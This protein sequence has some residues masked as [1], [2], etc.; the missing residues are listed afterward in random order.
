M[1][2]IS[3]KGFEFYWDVASGG[4]EIVDGAKYRCLDPD[5][6]GPIAEYYPERIFFFGESLRVE[7]KPP[8]LI[9]N[10]A[11]EF[12]PPKIYK[13]LADPVL[14]RKFASLKTENLE[15]EVLGFASKYGM[16]GPTL[17]LHPQN[18]SAIYLM[19]P[20]R[21]TD[22][23]QRVPIFP[24]RGE[25]LRI[26]QREID[27]MGVLLA[28]W[29]LIRHEK[30]G[31]L[32]QIITWRG[33]DAVVVRFKWKPANGRYEISPADDE[34][35]DGHHAGDLLANDGNPTAFFARYRR[36]DILGPA[37]HYVCDM[38]NHHL[39]GITPRLSVNSGYKVEYTPKS[40]LDALWLMFMLEVDGTTTTCWH[41]GKSFEPTRKDNVYCSNNCKRM[42]FYHKNTVKGGT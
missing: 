30:V 20:D 33:P 38:L 16:L 32:G 29:D 17:R 27:K 36:G 11:Q 41:C 8:W 24:E 26:W 7:T 25:S 6:P 39:A 3:T 35:S 21:F 1:A 5:P 13:P 23:S 40:L 22:N 19:D 31:K 4:Y 10:R 2:D 14:H 15:T 12:T 28:I 42:A 18:L 9:S 34:K 37:R